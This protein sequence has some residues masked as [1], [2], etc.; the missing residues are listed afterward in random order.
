MMCEN[1]VCFR[2]GTRSFHNF[3]PHFHDASDGKS[4]RPFL[5]LQMMMLVS[6]SIS[7]ASLFFFVPFLSLHSSSVHTPDSSYS[8]NNH[9]LQHKTACIFY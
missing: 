4:V 3:C 8:T 1:D 7:V 6:S 2:K 5:C 9:R